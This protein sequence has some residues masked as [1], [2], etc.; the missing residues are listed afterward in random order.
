[1][2]AAADYERT[3]RAM[4][5]MAPGTQGGQSRVASP[6]GINELLTPSALQQEP[7]ST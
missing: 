6:A 7:Q 2:N 3:A 4:R 1:M 5:R